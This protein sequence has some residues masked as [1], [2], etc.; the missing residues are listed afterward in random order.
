[1][2]FKLVI[3]LFMLCIFSQNV[4]AS[5]GQPT[6][7]EM[8]ALHE[9]QLVK[10]Q[11]Q[12]QAGIFIKQRDE[13]LSN[14]KQLIIAKKDSYNQM[15]IAQRDYKTAR[16]KFNNVKKQQAN[17]GSQ[18]VELNKNKSQLDKKV[19]QAQFQALNQSQ[20]NLIGQMNNFANIQQVAYDN[21]QV[22]DA[23]YRNLSA[24][25][26]VLKQQIESVQ[27]QLQFVLSQP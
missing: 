7:Q 15:M 12:Q 1:M 26:Q 3:A 14:Y 24:K 16:S 5:S 4:F 6:I 8:R 18:I 19:F 11:K 21:M 13:L 9:Q 20:N 17:L 22:A 27:R 2:I 25:E 23:Q 10:Q